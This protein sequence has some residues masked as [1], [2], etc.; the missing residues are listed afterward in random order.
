MRLVPEPTDGTRTVIV[1]DGKGTV[2]VERPG[3][4]WLMCGNCHAPL[5]KGVPMADVQNVVFRCKKCGECNEPMAWG[6]R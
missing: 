6:G 5:V 4:V 1:H 2:V 3:N